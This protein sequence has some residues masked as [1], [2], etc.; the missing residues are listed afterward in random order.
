MDHKIVTQGETQLFWLDLAKSL[1]SEQTINQIEL[2]SG[3][4]IKEVLEQHI[5]D[6]V[7]GFFYSLQLL[8]IVCGSIVRYM[9]YKDVGRYSL[10]I[11]RPWRYKVKIVFHML[12]LL[13]WVTFA[14]YFAFNPFHHD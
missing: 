9:H 13:L 4:D 2:R 1:L 10:N 11:A 6:I 8:I 3:K 7:I 12:M 14:V 5:Y